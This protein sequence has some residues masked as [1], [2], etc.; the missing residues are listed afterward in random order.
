MYR[1]I[2]FCNEQEQFIG[3]CTASVVVRCIGIIIIIVK[4]STFCDPLTPYSLLSP[5]PAPLE[6]S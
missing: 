5:P 6:G 4:I 1:C 3:I 2:Y